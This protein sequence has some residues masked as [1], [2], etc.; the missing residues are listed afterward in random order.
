MT[1]PLL[2]VAMW[3]NL[4]DRITEAIFPI[5]VVFLCF[6]YFARRYFKD[7]SALRLILISFGFG[8]AYRMLVFFIG[9]PFPKRYFFPLACTGIILATPGFVA[10]CSLLYQKV[11]LR[12]TK[13][14]IRYEQL[15][16]C[17]VL[18]VS[19]ICIGKG[20]NPDFDKAWINEIADE[21]KKHSP[22]GAQP[23]LITNSSDHRIAYYAGAF[24]LYYALP[25][26]AIF[27]LNKNGKMIDN[28][29]KTINGAIVCMGTGPIAGQNIAI[30]MPYGLENL[31]RNVE[32]LGGER[33][34]FLMEES[35]KAFRARFSRTGNP[36]PL[37]LIK[38]YR[39][40]KAPV[41]SLYQGAPL[42]EDKKE[43]LYKKL[44]FKTRFD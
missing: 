24:Y 11:I 40:R 15:I 37:K 13:W 3:G 6:S 19:L 20:L 42:P 26:Y 1:P 25:P 28:H 29:K 22:A 2:D 39:E 35:D 44:K 8:L 23:V 21:I 33:V 43:L 4:L 14:K 36:F 16:F 27:L 5:F 30:D 12:F 9:V 32:E 18:I 34:F 10:I 38:E 31:G 7:V 17:C 41:M